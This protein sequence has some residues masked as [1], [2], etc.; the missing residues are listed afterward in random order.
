MPLERGRRVVDAFAADPDLRRD[1]DLRVGV[2]LAAADFAA[3]A[4]AAGLVAVDFA[5]DAAFAVDAGLRVDAALRV[6]V[7]LAAARFVPLEDAFRLV[8]AFALV[9][10][11]R[12][13]VFALVAAFLVVAAPRLVADFALVAARD[14][15]A[16]VD[17]LAAEAFAV[18]VRR[19]PPGF[20]ADFFGEVAEARRAGSALIGD[21]TTTALAAAEPTS[22]AAPLTAPPT[23]D[24]APP[25]AAPARW[26]IRPAMTATSA[27]ASPACLRRLATCFRPFDAWASASWRSRLVS[28][29]R[30]A[31]NWRSSLPS[32]LA[33]PL[34]SGTTTAR[35]SPTSPLAVRRTT[36]VGALRSL[37]PPVVFAMVRRLPGRASSPRRPT[38]SWAARLS[39]P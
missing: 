19:R 34:D 10:A 4:C 36:S 22:L 7:G 25:A 26:P 32:S 6:G 29:W 31:F 9:A 28:V 39:S 13:A 21:T 15:V 12:M 27:A 1:P 16:D 24:A 37:D 11:F 3:A 30:A 18:K 14:A 8:A 2:D 35:A 17:V 5:A 33:A 20:D 38:R 23:A